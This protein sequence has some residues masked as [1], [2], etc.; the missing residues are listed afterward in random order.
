MNE[1]LS[2]EEMKEFCDSLRNWALSRLRL[3]CIMSHLS[4]S[5][6]YTSYTSSCNLVNLYR[7]IGTFYLFD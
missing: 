4:S 3:R 2:V 5:L 7:P 6:V 1:L